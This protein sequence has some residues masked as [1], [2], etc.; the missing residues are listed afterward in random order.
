MSRNDTYLS[1]CLAQAELSPLH[2]RHG[3]II[4]RGGKVIG[5]GFN[6]HRPGFDGGSLKTGVLPSSALALNSPAIAELKQRLK[7]KPKPMSKLDPDSHLQSTTFTPFETVG[8]GCSA[9]GA[10]SLHSEM[11]AIQSAL[12][13]SSAAQAAQTSARGAKYFEKPCFS[14]LPGD[15]KERKLRASALRAYVESVIAESAEGGKSCGGNRVLNRVHVNQVSK[16]MY[17][18]SND[19]EKDSGFYLKEKKEKEK[20]KE[21]ENGDSHSYHETYHSQCKGKLDLSLSNDFGINKTSSSPGPSSKTSSRE[22]FTSKQKYQNKNHKKHTQQTP[23]ETEP[24]LITKRPTLSSKPSIASRIKD[25]RLKG[26]DLYVARLG[27]CTAQP[28]KPAKPS[29]PPRSPS[30]PSPPPPEKRSPTSLH[31]ELSPHLHTSISPS[32]TPNPTPSSKPEI[33]ASQKRSPTSLHDELSPHLHTSISPSP[34]PNPTPSSK[35]EIRASR[36]CYRCV[37]AMHAVGI[38][39]VFWTNAEGS[40]EGAKVR[41]LVDALEGG[42]GVESGG[43]VDSVNRGF[44]VTKHEVL[45]LKRGMEGGR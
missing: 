16:S 19:K 10:L 6:S 22:N 32:P 43:G 7:S 1:L 45:A 14:L 17:N 2:Y 12:S 44:F 23:L 18:V 9:N 30:P 40:W 39:R 20:E 35:P 33:R 13:L 8:N 3:A 34:T 11:M 42:G 29:I 25:S 31:D 41:D 37:T 5:Q 27:Q 15:S 28:L 4:V 24:V 38:K 26:S 36:P 21:K